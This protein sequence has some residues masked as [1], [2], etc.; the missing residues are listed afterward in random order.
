MCVYYSRNAITE[1]P[2][3]LTLIW[4]LPVSDEYILFEHTVMGLNYQCYMYSKYQG[5]RT[6]GSGEEKFWRCSGDGH[7]GQI[8]RLQKQNFFP[9]SH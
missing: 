6:S 4:Y 3:R 1:D 5:S 2:S 8:T 9:P 7:H